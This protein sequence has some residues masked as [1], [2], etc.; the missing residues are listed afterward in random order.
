MNYFFLQKRKEIMIALGSPAVYLCHLNREHTC[1]WRE[2]L[3]KGGMKFYCNPSSG[4]GL[5]LPHTDSCNLWACSGCWHGVWT[6]SKED[7]ASLSAEK[8]DFTYC[9]RSQ[10]GIHKFL[11]F[12]CYSLQARMVVHG[13]RVPGVCTGAAPETNEE[14]SFHSGSSRI[15]HFRVQGDA[16][17]D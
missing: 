13:A 6:L 17:L 16:Q 10:E 2:F 15:Y 14:P 9:P 3:G 5:D 12:M 1:L 7:L 8:S 4:A 11:V